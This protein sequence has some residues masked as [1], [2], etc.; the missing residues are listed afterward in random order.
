MVDRLLTNLFCIVFFRGEL[1]DNALVKL[2]LESN[3]NG[4]KCC[5]I[6][7]LIKSSFAT[8]CEI[9]YAHAQIGN[10][11][12]VLTLTIIDPDIVCIYGRW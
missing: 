1:I 11:F 3:E 9:W 4:E 6:M 12:F 5:G 10:G 2:F 8:S 7:L